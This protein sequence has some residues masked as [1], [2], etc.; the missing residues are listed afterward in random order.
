MARGHPVDIATRSFP[1]K[2]A[3]KKF[4]S[5]M[6]HRYRAGDRVNDADGLELL[7]LL[8]RHL[9]YSAKVGCGVDHFEVMDTEEGT[10]CFRVVRTDGSGD[11]FSF[12]HC[13]GQ[14]PPSRKQEVSKAFRRVVRFDLYKARDDF[15]TA[16]K[17]AEGLVKCAET[18]E[19]IGRDNA[20]MDHR[21]P[22]TFELIVTTF[23]AQ[24]GLSLDDVPI[25]SG[26]EE[27]VSP[28]ITDRA[29]AD[30]FRKYHARVAQVDLVKDTANLSQSARNRLKPTRIR[31]V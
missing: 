6:L 12:N 7:A 29:L 21:A 9:E 17:D 1:S 8:E 2:D 23:L 19:R 28:D 18:A 11:D 14:R 26:Q 20:H 10:P 25:T 31:L 27:Q 15:F 5:E 3:A 13:I 16:N 24:K 22:T 4:F 30:E